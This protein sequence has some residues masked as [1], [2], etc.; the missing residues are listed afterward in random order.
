MANLTVSTDVDNFMQ[1]VDNAAARTS[2]GVPATGDLAGY[3]ATSQLGALDGVAQLD[4]TGV[5]VSS[6]IPALTTA[7]I[8]QITPAVIG[9]VATSDLTTLAT[10][11]GVLQLDASGTISTDQLATIASLPSGAQGSSAVIPVVTVDAKG[12]VTA[13]T[14][15]QAVVYAT[16]T[17]LADYVATSQLG[18][19]SGVAQLDGSGKLRTGQIPALTT[20]QIAQITPAG[21]GAVPT[22]RSITS[23]TGLSG[24]GDLTEDRTLAVSYGT[25]SGTAAQGNDSRLSDSR[26]PTAHASTHGAGGTDAITSIALTSAS[27]ITVTPSSANDIVNKAYADAIASSINFHDACDYATLAVL[28]PAATYNQPGGVGV[29]VGATLTGSTNAAL[30]VDGVTVSTTQ[31]ILVKNQAS[32]FQNGIYT[33]TQQGNGSTVPYILTRA[34]DY[35]TSG[36]APNEVQAGDFVLVLN[37][38]L[39]NTAWVQQ[40]P[41]PINFG[42]TAINFIQ[43]AAA[44]AGV[45]TFSADNTG[46]T[47]STATNG[48]VTLGGTL[49]V[50]HGGTGAATLTGFVKAAGTDAFTAISSIPA[51]SLSGFSANAIVKADGAGLVTTAAAGTDYVVPSG[52]ITGTSAN[53]TGTVAIGNGGTGS[54]TQLAAITALT[55][56]QTLGQ[57]LRS[58]GTNPVLSA[59]QAGDVPTLNQNTTGTAANVTG[60]VAIANGGTGATTAQSAISNLGIG[61]RMVEAQTTAS[62]TGTIVGNVFTVT[63]T[64][65]FTTDGYTPVLG[66]IIAFALQGGGTSTQNGFWEVT[67]VGAVG[68]SAVFTRPNWFTGTVKNGMYMTRFGTNQSGY[69]MAF[70][71]PGGSADITVGTSTIQ[72]TRVNQ[73]LANATNSI[74]L[75]TGYQTFRASGASANQ[76]PFFF[77]A[78]VALMTAPQAHA[79][80][81]FNDNMYLTTS[82]SVRNTNVMWPTSLAPTQGQWLTWDNATTR[83]VPNT[84]AA[85]DATGNLGI[86]TTSP[87]AKTEIN[88]TTDNAAA[89]RSRL[90]VSGG[91]NNPYI[92]IS[93]NEATGFS[94]IDANGSTTT[95]KNLV[96]ATANTERLRIDSS[97]NVYPTSGTQAMTAGFQWIGA[98]AGTPS[99]TPSPAVSGRVPLYYDTT[100]NKLYVYNGGWKGS[101]VFS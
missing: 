10:A 45:T 91:T 17:Q 25:T 92:E 12:R 64:G 8:A 54:T 73:R 4:G 93:H 49:N 86:G 88:V 60:T 77:Q 31:R 42:V 19:L 96:L 66:D 35:D 82:A 76:A 21:I 9:A 27:T 2:L 90:L 61:M 68:V 80:E 59:I 69:V 87:N 3:V 65:V 48:T 101:A 34:T 24:G 62:I 30:Q 1:A 41:A 83:W 55:G 51:S 98:A 78:G 18:A 57:Y 52:N 7:Q 53:V 29:G 74:N 47:P 20:S 50:A 58:N 15:S 95:A 40:T 81:W 26:T 5:L 32:Q 63:A 39:A 56:T 33:V 94:K 75:F 89:L 46:F 6:Q 43:F 99:G 70:F 72:V 71:G 22:A 23:G 28:S 37:S 79:V 100:A 67:T 14:T 97:G 38:T 13:L 36:S 44:A 85:I 84:N 11:N 16:T